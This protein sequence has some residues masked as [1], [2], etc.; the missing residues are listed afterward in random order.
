MQLGISL[1]PECIG[2]NRCVFFFCV[3]VCMHVQLRDDNIFI[4]RYEM[5]A[6]IQYILLLMGF[7]CVHS[8]RVTI[9]T[10]PITFIRLPVDDFCRTLITSSLKC[11][12]FNH[13]DNQCREFNRCAYRATSAVWLRRIHPLDAISSEQN[14]TRVFSVWIEQCMVFG[15]LKNFWEKFMAFLLVIRNQFTMVGI[16]QASDCI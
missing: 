8:C 7:W 1:Q 3:C 9:L 10:A 5:L 6:S 14:R 12:S 15:H 13:L 16:D 4:I 11:S 2:S